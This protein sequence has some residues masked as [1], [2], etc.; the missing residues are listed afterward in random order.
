M[1]VKQT[2]QRECE[3]TDI[4]YYANEHDND[5]FQKALHS[6]TFIF[7]FFE[8]KLDFLKIK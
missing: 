3:E 8:I 5:R 1:V 7:S 2:I 4:F 6:E